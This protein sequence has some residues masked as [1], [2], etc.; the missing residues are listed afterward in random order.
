MWPTRAKR[1]RELA[2][3]LE[4]FAAKR[5]PL[6][7]IADEPARTAL[8][9]QMIASLRRLEY[10]QLLR[11]RV[12]STRRVD[13]TDRMFDP[14]QA[15]IVYAANGE[16]DEA[17]WLIFLATHF[18]KHRRTGWR[19]LIDVYSGL[20]GQRWSWARVSKAPQE[21]DAWLAEHHEAIG[22]AFGNHRKYETLKPKPGKG[23]G[24]IIASYVAWV[25]H[26]RS[27][28]DLVKRLV[29]QGGNDPH[30]IFDAFYR[31]MTVLRFGRLARFDFLALIGR[32]G[33][34]PIE[35]GSA[36]LLQATGPRRGA[37]LLFLGDVDDKSSDRS[38]DQWL[39]ELDGTLKV[40]M[41]VLEDS[42]CNWQKSPRT[43]VHFTG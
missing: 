7:G 36:Y 31:S 43:F 19:R 25:G 26:K 30:S 16:I 38:L 27:H 17:F 34:A 29:K 33:L 1:F 6:P 2:K 42:L 18:G 11:S 37:R 35:P 5:R 23:T 28:R 24:S 12:P 9:W 15:A 10:T 20:G 22:G 13:P 41:Q 40:G 14:E 39:V 8:A 4:T 3:A 32:L 21:F